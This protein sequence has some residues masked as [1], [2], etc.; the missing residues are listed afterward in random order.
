MNKHR[1]GIHI[2]NKKNVS[3]IKSIDDILLD[4]LEIGIAVTSETDREKLYDIIVGKCMEITNCD[5]GVLYLYE[6]SCLTVKRAVRQSGKIKQALKNNT[7]K[8]TGEVKPDGELHNIMTETVINGKTVNIK[9][10]EACSEYELELIN[11]RDKDWDF[12]TK[13]CLFIPLMNNTG[14]VIGVLNLCNAA[15]EKGNI[16]SFSDAFEKIIGALCCQAASSVSNIVYVE[17]VKTL[18]KSFVK[19]MATAIDERTPYNGS[20]TRKVTKYVGIIVDYINECHVAGKTDMY[21]TEDH[22]E[23][24]LLA[25]TLHDIG[26][27]VVPLS[28][29]NKSTKL[30]HRYHDVLARY[31]LIEAYLKI[32]MLEGRMSQQKYEEE[33]SLLCEVREFVEYGN[34][35]GG[36]PK[37]ELPIID[38]VINK[39]YTKPDGTVLRYMSEYEAE[40]MKIERGT[41]TPDE[42]TVMHSHVEM[43]EK[44]LSHIH[45]SKD[46][47][48]VPVWASSHH[49][50][51]DGSGYSKKLKGDEIEPEARLLAVVDIYDALT[52][53]DRPYKKPM[54]SERAY[55]ELESMV[56]EGKLDGL[57]VEYL[58]EA[59]EDY[60]LKNENTC[61][62]LLGSR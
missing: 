13:T 30:G 57:Y 5:L 46:Y 12:K 55:E 58:K 14:G 15:D 22:K 28:I 35:G 49:E 11:Q 23:N 52:S 21:Y 42:R 16:V 41:L 33:Y 44:I 51:L 32:D 2:M 45:F 56:E 61:D 59:L 18:M 19:A 39:T 40:C 9:D 7:V 48:K 54:S 43:T 62:L 3:N 6:E 10:T 36:I 26:K 4:V 8:F 60:K 17:E 20:H 1:S 31:D 37:D 29:M 25:A 34:T 38:R 53:A 47:E 27:M 50:M 24:L